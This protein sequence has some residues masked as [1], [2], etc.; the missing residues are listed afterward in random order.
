MSKQYSLLRVEGES[1]SRYL[2]SAL[3][4]SIIPRKKELSN[5]KRAPGCLG[6]KGDEILPRSM[7]IIRIPLKQAVQWKVRGFLIFQAWIA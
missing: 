5:E 2:L 1:F 6:Y 7:E 3:V 4:R